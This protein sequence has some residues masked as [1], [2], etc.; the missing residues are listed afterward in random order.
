MNQK[1]IFQQ[2]IDVWYVLPAIRKEFAMEMINLGLSQKKIAK[3]LGVTEAAISQYK[4]EKRAKDLVF[5]EKAK[6]EIKK[7][8]Q[9]IVEQPELVFQEMMRIDDFLKQN[10]IFCQIHRSKS[11]TPDGCESV[12]ENHFFNK[13]SEVNVQWLS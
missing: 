5:D 3:I 6:A 8:A 2:E 1:L 11:W 7:A 12:C 4:N 13:K 9:K 10:R